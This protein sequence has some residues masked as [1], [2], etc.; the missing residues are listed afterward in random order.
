MWSSLWEDAEASNEEEKSQE[1]Q[2]PKHEEIFNNITTLGSHEKGRKVAK[3][4][5][6][7]HAS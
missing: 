2:E 1:E 4:F 5:I 6:A 7:Q 3:T